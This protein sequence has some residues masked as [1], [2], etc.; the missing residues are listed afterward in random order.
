MHKR[1][2]NAGFTFI[3]LMIAMALGLI[4]MGAAVQLY[5]QAMKATWVTSERSE[6]QQDF[7][8]SS[9]LLARDLS[10]AGAG[11]L[12]QQGLSSNSVALPT[13]T[14][15]V[16]PCSTTTC[17]Y[18]NSAPVSYPLVSGARYLYSI[19]PGPNF[20]I[21]VNGKTTDIITISYTDANLALNCY[22]VTYVNSSTMTFTA[23]PSGTI[24]STCILPSTVTAPQ[25]LND[26]VVGLQSGDMILFSTSS[27]SAAIAV[28]TGAPT[29]GSTPCGSSSCTTYTVP[30]AIGSDPGHINQASG[31]GSLSSL[32]G[33]TL[34]SAVR[35]LVITYYL[36]ISPTDGVTPRLMRIQNGKPPAPVAENVTY[37]KFTY[38][39]YNGGTVVANQSSLPAGT[40]PAMITK[41]N[42]AHMTIRSQVAGVSGY[43][44]LDLQTSVSARNLTFY[45]E[46][47]ISGSSY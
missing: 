13:G 24:P 7:R 2:N 39:C 33:H 40:T 45:Q 36:D 4:V 30:F 15:P 32:S 31:T 37:L 19:I 35:L 38:D 18:I 8:A 34:Q 47:P 16:Y 28:V 11:A 23:P 26:P 3:E 46:Y 9:N 41:I 21:T 27:G 17:N 25:P 20:G 6:M 43:Q 5:S 44:G 14:T 29:V 10:M 42:I 12:G 1:A 22:S